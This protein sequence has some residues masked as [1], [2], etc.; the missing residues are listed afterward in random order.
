MGPRR[1]NTSY[2]EL[3]YSVF[4]NIKGV[5]TYIATHDKRASGVGALFYAVETSTNHGLVSS[6]TREWKADPTVDAS[7]SS[8][9]YKDGLTEVRVN[10][11]RALALIRAY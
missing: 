7:R 11:L 1:S 9:L 10:S 2:E 8:A 4:P 6:E 3:C 5:L